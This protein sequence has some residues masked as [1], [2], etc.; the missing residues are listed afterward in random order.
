VSF[1]TIARRPG[2]ANTAT[3]RARHGAVAAWLFTCCALIFA[4]VVVGGVTRLTLSGLSI[5]EWNPVIGIVPPLT[6]AQW[7]AEFARYRQIPEYRLIHY[8]MSLAEFKGIYFWEYA[9]RL[10]GRLIGVAYAVPLVWFLLRGRLPRRL[11]PALLGILA[12]GFGQ[13]LLGWYMVESGLVHRVEVSQYRLVAHLALALAIYS[14][15][16]W[17]AL[18]Q[19]RE[20]TGVA[21]DPSAPAPHPSL[22]RSRGRV[23]EGARWRRAAEA[24]ILLVG[25]TIAAGGFVA[26]TRAGLTYNTFPLM[27]G[28]L[29][30]AGYAQLHPF[31]RNW[32]ENIPAIQFDH[33]LLAMT[34]IAAV[35]LQWAAGL[36][37]ALP[38]PTRTALWALL[39]A[40]AVQAALGISTLLLVVPVALAAAHQAGAVILLTAA[41]VLR[42]TL[43]RA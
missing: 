26:G 25:L 28:R 40:A 34:T 5:T 2:A 20:P 29:V 9:H 3:E 4:M 38:A 31:I 42:H 16:L 11:V 12:L 35:L 32:F 30:P 19:I 22:P 8:G 33:R 1:S 23:R 17:T 43:R 21:F 10:L 13:G 24:V 27:D 37:A 7:A 18:G 41:I 36:R 14:L 15:I 39:A 6:E